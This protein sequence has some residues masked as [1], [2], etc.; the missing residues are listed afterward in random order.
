MLNRHRASLAAFGE[1]VAGSELA[2]AFARVHG[3]SWWGSELDGPDAWVWFPTGGVPW[4]G[5]NPVVASL[6]T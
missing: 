1:L 2:V 3:S 5:F 4:G 6:E